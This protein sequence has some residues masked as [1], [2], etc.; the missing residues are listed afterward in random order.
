[1][2]KKSANSLKQI[3]SF[4][5]IISFV[6][7]APTIVRAE[8]NFQL[9]DTSI[10]G[11][12]DLKLYGKEE[13]FPSWLEVTHSGNKMLVGRYVAIVGSARPISKV[14]YNDSKVSFSIPPQWETG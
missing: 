13:I 11:R 14:N 3:I 10:E 4:L 7:V 6:L 12:W 1:M 9:K 5:L 2:K 8:N